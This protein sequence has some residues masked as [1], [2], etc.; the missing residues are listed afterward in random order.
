M[1]RTHAHMQTT[2]LTLAKTEHGKTPLP[3]VRPPDHDYEISDPAALPVNPV[4]S[5]LMLA[6][7]HSAYL[8]QAIDSVLT[9]QTDF[10][11]ELLIGEDC[12]TDDTREIALRYQ[13]QYPNLIRVIT[14]EENV[15]IRRNWQRLVLAGRGEFLAHLDGDD[16]WLPNKLMLQVT[17]LRQH[18]DCAGVYTNAITVDE[19]G[20]YV[21]L[22]NDV[23]EKQFT[24]A[25]L[26]RRGNFLNTSSMVFRAVFRDVLLELDELFIDYRIHLRLARYGALAQLN[27]PLTAY[28]INSVGSMVLKSNDLVRDLYWEAIM[29]VPRASLT[30]DDFACGIA[31]F[32]RRVALR[33]VRTRRWSLLG[34][35]VPRAFAASPYGLIR[36][37]MLVARSIIRTTGKE[38]AGRLHKGSDGHRLRVLYRR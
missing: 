38:L 1:N 17:F 32:L 11:I 18:P 14:A 33:T 7:N 34:I 2:V 22:F 3:G 20:Q 15:G 23:G 16:Y 35:W 26:L 9:Q 24:L 4:L 19:S 5:V 31:D 13:R 27:E 37:S 12:S 8:A 30:D 6:Y 10:P 29:D 25:E 21:G 28:R 36:T